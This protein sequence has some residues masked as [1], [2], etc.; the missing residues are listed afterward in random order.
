MTINLEAAREIARQIRLRDIG[1]M[2][3]IDFIDMPHEAQQKQV[4][5]ELEGSLKRDRT[6]TKVLGL[7]RLGLVE[8]TRKKNRQSLEDL[9]QKTCPSCRGTGK[10]DTEETI[11]IRIERE[12]KMYSQQQG[13]T[14]VLIEAHPAVAGKLIG[15]GGQNLSQME[16]ATGKTVFVRGKTGFSTGEYQLFSGSREEVEKR[17]LPVSKGQFLRV[18]VEEAH[19]HDPQDG[20][21]RVDGYIIEVSQAGKYVGQEVNV[22]IGQVFRTYAKASLA[23]EE[24]IR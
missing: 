4:L 19:A 7:T 11:A 6:R 17:A 16:R 3:L 2:I 22:R 8:M 23:E 14:A 21:A 12:L 18:R 9:L 24:R 15:P 20:I 13:G 10:V 1:G 5:D